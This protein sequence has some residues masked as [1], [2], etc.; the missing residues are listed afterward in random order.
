MSYPEINDEGFVSDLLS[1]K[2]F[3]SLKADPDRN[4]KDPA[5][6]RSD[7]LLS[8]HLK[9]H[10]YQLFVGNL[11]NPDT[12]Y[13][14]LH[15]GW[16][17][18]TGKTLGALYIAS[19][20]IKVYHKM[21]ANLAAKTQASRRNYAEMDRNTP[22]IFVL[23]FGGTKSAF[24]RDLLKYPE[25][26]FIS[27]MEKEELMKRQ[28]LAN[29]G[30]PDDIRHL[31]EYSS[32][33]KKRIWNKNKDGF[34]KFFGYDEFVNRLFHSDDIKLTD[35]EA[36]AIQK[37]RA[38]ETTTLED[39]FREYIAEGKIHVNT[40]L[41]AMFE[42]SLLICDEIH[43]TYNMNMKNNRGVAIQYVLDSVP[44]LRFLSMSATPINNS[45]TEIVELINYLVPKE[46]KISKKGFFSN[47]RTLIP[48]KL[49]EIGKL[50]AGRLSFI[51]DVDIKY[52]PRREFNGE[53]LF[54]P[55]EVDN[56]RAGD[57]IPYLKFIPCPMSKFHQATYEQHLKDAAV[58]RTGSGE[59]AD[60][61]VDATTDTGMISPAASANI[62]EVANAQESVIELLVEKNTVNS[63]VPVSRLV[64]PELPE[65]VDNEDEPSDP[66]ID[67]DAP[68][69]FAIG[70]PVYSYHS[71]PTDGYSIYDI[72]FP[73][74][75]SAFYGIFRSSEVRNKIMMASQEWRDT[76]K[77]MVKKYSVI[78]NIVTGDFLL[79]ENIAKYS[80]KMAKL[81]DM[82]NE[83]IASNESNVDKCQKVMIYHDRVKM[84]GV[85][86]IQELLRTNG[87]ID[88]FSEPTDNTKCCVCGGTLSGHPASHQYYPARYVVAHSD[89]DKPTMEQSLAKFNTPDNA[90]GLK[91]MILIGS[92][93][94]KQSY[95]FK[96]I[97]HLIIMSLPVNIPTLI[98]VFGR[99]VRKGSHINLPPSDRRVR[100]SILIS[101]MGETTGDTISPEMYRYIDKLTD[102]II[103][104]TIE[105][106]MNRNA[107]DGDINRDVIMPP[108]ILK[109]YFPE[110]DEVSTIGNLY[111]DPVY[112][113]GHKSL[114]ELT[115]STHTA[116]KYYEDEIKTITFIIK[117]LFM[118]Q[119]IWTYD[120][121]WERVKAPPIAIE[122][123]PKLFV[124]NNFI[125]A[126]HNLVENA[127]MIMSTAKRAEMTEARLVE[128]LFD[129]SERYIYIR[130]NRYK[131]EHIDKYYILFPIEDIPQNPL[132]IVYAEYMEHIRD[133]ERMMIKELS[134]PNDHVIVDVETY[135][136][137]RVP[138][139]GIRINI[140][141]YVRDSRASI[142]YVAKKNE[143]VNTTDVVEFISEYSAQFQMSFLE[144][145]IIWSFNGGGISAINTEA[146]VNKY[147]TVM[148]LLDKFKV[149]V[150]MKEIRKYRD[151]AKSFKNGLPTN[152][153]NTPIGYMTAKSVRLYDPALGSFIEVNKISLNRQFMYKENE[154]IVGFLESAEDHMKF[155]L[156]KPV[157][158]IREDVK[159]KDAVSDT[160][161]IERGI[162]CSTKNKYELLQI[163]ASLGIS[164]SKLDKNE[165][166]IKRLCEIIKNRLIESEIKERG[167]DSRYKYLYSW[168]DEPVALAAHV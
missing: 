34:F 48:G 27:V 33:L 9:I 29:S 99:C 53:T 66:V 161:L 8:G 74:P 135:I 21:Y 5:E 100:I 164:V 140:E 117:R 38:G 126:L 26:G 63:A 167:K 120:D 73:N 7:V 94:I 75:D 57:A 160:R 54:I 2:E 96:D 147:R 78:N 98:Q 104:Q 103:I 165:I 30:L 22:T 71:I 80:T 61:N 64:D 118:L 128:Q 157:Q 93:I 44:S 25:F 13:K 28:Q 69:E 81:I 168:W 137:S 163:I 6:A 145:A 111:F 19:K 119:P 154:I 49:E 50:T 70:A 84:S 18:G 85:L 16:T 149:I 114:S 12:P 131:I 122:V 115:T 31:K 123:N 106:E 51:Q 41:L 90:R 39:V 56:M 40:Q 136:R 151:I 1:R 166:R 67:E 142:N 68:E 112:S 60:V 121:L 76:H 152:D 59:D 83:I 47:T 65:G 148:E 113:I 132:N 129:S 92:K 95:D 101:T 79:R 156:R 133:K 86:L 37:L 52:F 24:I 82:L 159:G 32:M 141:N 138:R 116:Y 3:Y 11:M 134:E 150:Y 91:Y 4:F 77:I 46:Q 153:D 15:L 162:V 36:I 124:E 127:T 62:S 88:D 89:V 158:K 45:P 108:A 143:F 130:G 110:G 102:Y 155:K 107:I 97:Q 43:D 58:E 17:P 139:S 42:N 144:E 23:G 146:I 55:H 109:T 20:F 35:L 72:A 87:F 125:I 105:R 10:S 14:R